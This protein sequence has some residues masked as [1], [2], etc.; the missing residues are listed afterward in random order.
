MVI[1]TRLKYYLKVV[2][3]YISLM[4]EILNSFLFGFVYRGS[5]CLVLFIEGLFVWFCFIEGLFFVVV[6]FVSSLQG[7]DLR[8]MCAREVFQ[9]NLT[10]SPFAFLLLKTADHWLV[11]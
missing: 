10:P 3:I 6:S 9:L 4:T 8:L 2:S 1:L 7:I 5:F 11:C